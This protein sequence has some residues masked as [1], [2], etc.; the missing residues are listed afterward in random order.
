MS[1]DVHCEV[2]SRWDLGLNEGL[3]GCQNL[4][5]GV[6]QGLSRHFLA[7]YKADICAILISLADTYH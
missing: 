7:N 5:S 6:W 1:V 3:Y 4:F 2:K